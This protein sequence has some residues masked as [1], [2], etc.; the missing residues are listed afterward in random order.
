ME[1]PM[2]YVCKERWHYSAECRSFYPGTVYDLT[3]EDIEKF[4]AL[5]PPEGAMKYFARAEVPEEAPKAE[6][7]K[8]VPKE[9]SK[10]GG[11]K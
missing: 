7:P 11:K 5:K 4:K 1:T 2:K 9:P 10:E 6:A 8:E 3:G